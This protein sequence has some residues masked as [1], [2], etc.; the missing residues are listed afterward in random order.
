FNYYFNANRKMEEA[1]ANMQRTSRD[2]WDGRIALFIF[3]PARASVVFSADMYSRIHK[4]ALG[5]QIHD[6][7]TKWGDDLYLL[8]GK[9]Y[10][11]K[12]DAE[13]AANS[14]K[15]IVALREKEKADAAQTGASRT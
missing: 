10:Y 11:Y 3:D 4:A 9:A 2:K 1:E 15:Y 8:L 12:G 14:F 7:R 5:I 13:N 6:P